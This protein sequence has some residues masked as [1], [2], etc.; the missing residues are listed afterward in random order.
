MGIQ[1][2]YSRIAS[3]VRPRFRNNLNQ[4]K[5]DEEVKKF[6]VYAVLELLDKIFE[7]KVSAKFGE[8]ELG[9]GSK[10]PFIIHQRIMHDITFMN[11]WFNSDLPMIMERFA[12]TAINHLKHLEKMPDKTESKMFPTPSHGGHSLTSPPRPGNR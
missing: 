8:I 5:S 7:G 6:F 11:A 3:K 10:Q 1:I 9:K 4:A 2:S 12:A